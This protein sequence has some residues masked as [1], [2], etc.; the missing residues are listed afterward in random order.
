M[1]IN[2]P[3]TEPAPQKL[4]TGTEAMMPLTHNLHFSEH[5]P[6]TMPTA[7]SYPNGKILRAQTSPAEPSSSWLFGKVPD[8]WVALLTYLSQ[9]RGTQWELNRHIRQEARGRFF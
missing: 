5:P 8:R 3:K 1:L 7:I 2:Y 6:S 4:P 9:V